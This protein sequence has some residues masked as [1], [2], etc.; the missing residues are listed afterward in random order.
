MGQVLHLKRLPS[1]LLCSHLITYFFRNSKM[2]SLINSFKHVFISLLFLCAHDMLQV[3]AKW[4][5]G[6]STRFYDFKVQMLKVTK[7]CHARN[8]VTINQMY[9][10][11]VV[12]A[13]E[14]DRLI[15]KL[16]NETPYNA[17]IH[18]HGV[19]QIL[20]CWSDGPSYITQCPVQS[21]QTFTYEF[22]LIKQ[23]GTLF[24]HA[25]FSWLRASVYG[26]YWNKDLV[27]LERNV[28]A[29]GGPAPVAEAYTINGHPGP[30]YNCSENGIRLYI[31]MENFIACL[32]LFIKIGVII[33]SAF[34]KFYSL[35]GIV[36]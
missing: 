9:P 30:N 22:T 34:G 10:G 11:P 27:Q 19:R 15:I 24:W 8:I 4:P 7:L 14:D 28:L 1:M 29:S 26:E 23:K 31:K 25:H 36:Y 20:S 3:M 33:G 5:K 35:F 6:G 16:T 18:W 17:S 2:A 32:G 13:Q 21:G 12:Y